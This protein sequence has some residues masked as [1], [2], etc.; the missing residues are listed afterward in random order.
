[1]R[2]GENRKFNKLSL[3]QH[4]HPDRNGVSNSY[5]PVC[6][7]RYA[8]NEQ[9]GLWTHV[10]TIHVESGTHVKIKLA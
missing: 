5:V 6:V 10:W 2:D 1:M 9:V 7:Y 3:R 4:S 8:L